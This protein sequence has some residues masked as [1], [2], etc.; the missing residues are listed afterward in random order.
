MINTKINLVLVYIFLNSK[1][2]KAV[3]I[4]LETAVKMKLSNIENSF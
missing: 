2:F 4:L 1:D 3:Q